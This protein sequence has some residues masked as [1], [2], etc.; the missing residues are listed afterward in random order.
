MPLRSALRR[1]LGA[2]LLATACLATG[3]VGAEV[4]V[5]KRGVNFELWQRWTNRDRFLA[6]DYDR[7]NFPDWTKV[8]SDAKLTALR[9][10]GFDFVRLN[11]DPSALMWDEPRADALVASTLRAVRR[12]QALDF[13]VVVDLHLVPESPDRPDGLHYVLGTGDRRP[14]E[15]FNRYLAIVRAFATEMKTF[16]ADKTALELLNEPDQDWFSQTPLTDRWPSQLA[17]LHRAARQAAPKLPLVLSG[18]RGGDVKGLLRVDASRYRNDDA[19]IWSFHYY[20]PG[21]ITH[22]GLP[23]ERSIGHFLTGLPFPAARLDAAMR[24][25]I[26]ERVV[27]AIRAE[28]TDPARRAALEEELPRAIDKYVA[29]KSGP[30]TIRDDIAQVLPWAKTYDVPPERIMMGEF[31]VFQDRVAPETRADIIRATREAAEAAGFSWAIYTA[32]LTVARSSFGIIDDTTT[33][34]VDDH[35]ARALGLR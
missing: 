22:S 2:A 12:L 19:L 24:A 7:D 15:G 34:R 3:T 11:V 18:P 35:V 1:L 5:L 14:S 30:E 26:T 17:A 23:W 21:A 31:G 16:P 8:V 28:I 32:G 10:Q 33:M 6:P 13:K 9:R 29:S 27:K 4:P 25:E 20:D